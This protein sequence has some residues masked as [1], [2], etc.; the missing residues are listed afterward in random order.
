M[1]C[2]SI[3]FYNAGIGTYVWILSNHK[4][5]HCKG[6]LQLIDTTALHT[7]M[8]NLLGSKRKCLSEEQIA[9]IRRPQGG[10]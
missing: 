6:Q 8:R 2:L 9:G 10:R 1:L 5:A 4:A 7:P 3:L